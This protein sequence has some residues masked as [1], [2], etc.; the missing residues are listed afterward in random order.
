VEDEI[1]LRVYINVLIRYWRLI[2]GLTLVAGVAAFVVG[3]LMPAMYQ[4]TAV[5][6]V[7][8]P[9]YQFQL[10]PGI[11]NLPESAAGTQVL[12]GKAALDLAVS[13][14]MI[15]DLLDQVGGDLPPAERFLL[16]M[17]AMLKAAQ[18]GDA[19]II[20]L[21][22]TNRN[23]QRV[24]KITNAWASLYVQQVNDLYGQSA[25]QL[26]FFEDQLA[27][28]KGDLDTADQA[29]VDFQKRNDAAVLQAQLAAKQ[30]ALSNYLNLN[31]SLKL[32][33]QN[34]YSLQDQLARQPADAPSTLGNDLAALML[35][36][37]TFSAQPD[38]ANPQEAQSSL[39]I[40]LQLPSTGTL[41]NKTA[42]QQV[43]YLAD[44]ARTIEAKQIEV[45][46]QADAAPTEIMALQGQIQESNT[47]NARLTRQRDMA[48]S[49][50]TTLSQ[51]VGETRIAT[52]NTSGRVRLASAAA[53][54]EKPLGGKLKN[55]AIA[56]VLGLFLG[57]VVALAI[58]YFKQ[59]Q[60][61]PAARPA[62]VP[63]K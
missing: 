48:Q 24:A 32:L 25:E 37:N 10:A 57:I 42:G 46:K 56:A 22:V 16:P 8:R 18:G 35:Q 23:P 52:Q 43:A 29:L 1:D 55:T 30:S 50:Y 3:L 31:E 2:V 5:V 17:R 7:T 36:V 38:S 63:G 28:A 44:L 26:K 58:E 27:Q 62:P 45:K 19:S 51:K 40:Q 53:V 15:Q 20:R 14:A 34:V 61:E 39:P 59:P 54:P 21:T 4:A 49:V 9:L 60:V 12:S 33:L 6:V 13:D 11:E 41:S 47:E